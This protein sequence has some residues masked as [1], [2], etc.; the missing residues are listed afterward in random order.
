MFD[1]AIPIVVE[2]VLS[3]SYI[4][5]PSSSLASFCLGLPLDLFPSIFPSITVFSSDSPI[6]VCPIHFF[7]L[8]FIAVADP[9]RQVRGGGDLYIS[10]LGLPGVRYLAGL[11]GILDLYPV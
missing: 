6:R 9:G 11:S 8:V 7:C 3:A 5:P 4:L 2:L 10:Y 1:V